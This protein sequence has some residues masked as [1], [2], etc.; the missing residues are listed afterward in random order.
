M[1]WL[2]EINRATSSELQIVQVLSSSIS[3]RIAKFSSVW[4][5][6]GWYGCGQIGGNDR[7]DKIEVS[8]SRS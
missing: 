4:R 6:N 7:C 8:G 5:N 1:E 3:D 2:S